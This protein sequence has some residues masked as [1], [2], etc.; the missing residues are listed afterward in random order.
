MQRVADVGAD[1]DMVDVEQRQFLVALLVERL[2][3]LVGDFLA[4]FGIDFT[5]LRI[6]Q[7]FGQIVADQLF[8]R[9]PQRLEALFLHLTRT[10]YGQ[11][12][13]GLEHGPCRCRR[14]SGR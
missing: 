12:L 7:I 2:Q 14:R 4:G 8:I 10:T 5:G 3:R 9:Q 1:I 11:F 6:D 13:A